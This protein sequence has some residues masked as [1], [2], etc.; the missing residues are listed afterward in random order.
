VDHSILEA[1]KD[2][3]LERVTAR[4]Y[5]PAASGG[6]SIVYRASTTPREDAVRI[7]SASAF[8]LSCVWV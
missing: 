2:D 3:G 6:A 1:F 7:L 5:N 4:V 8:P